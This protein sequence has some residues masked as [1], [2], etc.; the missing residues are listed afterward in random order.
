MSRTSDYA[1]RMIKAQAT[2]PSLWASHPHKPDFA[3]P[4]QPVL[5]Q[6]MIPDAEGKPP[7][8]RLNHLND[9]IDLEADAAL[10]LARWIVEVFS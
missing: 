9:Q 4:S 6:V 1:D 2:R 3:K 5:A 7:R 10:D 8:M